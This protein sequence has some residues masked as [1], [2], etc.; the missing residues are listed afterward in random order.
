MIAPFAVLTVVALAAAQTD[1]TI[2]VKPGA[3]LELSNFAG[4]I[5]VE[6]WTKNAIR[7]QANHSSRAEV[8]INENGPSIS[9]D[10]H[11]WRG[12][13]TSV[14]YRLTV[15]KWMALELSGVNTEISVLGA[16][17]DVEAQSVE[18]DV[19]ITGGRKVTAGSVSGSV[20]VSGAQ[21]RVECSSVNAGVEVHKSS[22]AISASSVN[23]E[24]VFDDID[25]DDVEASTVNGEVRF[26]GPFKDD[27]SYRFGSHNG[28]VVVTVPEGTNA[29]VSVST[30]SGGFESSFEVPLKGTKRGKS[31]DFTLGSGGARIELES[32]QG[33]ILLRRPGDPEPK[34]GFDYQYQY[35]Q[36]EQKK[37]K[38]HKNDA[39]DEP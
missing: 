36:K 11:H 14:D 7:V 5:A 30:F 28:S 34:T 20:R 12:I 27:G 18:G 6:T 4:E 39:H 26:S 37:Q 23:G 21:G 16:Q 31:F 2:N 22:G 13:P 10:I 24:V 32:F 19:S 9:I 3:R 17:G 1:T 8:E 15:P 35:E 38:K 33:S 25:S 29:S